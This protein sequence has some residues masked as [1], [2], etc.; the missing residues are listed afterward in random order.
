MKT[1]YSESQI[2][3]KGEIYSPDS[4]EILPKDFAQSEYFYDEHDPKVDFISKDRA[5]YEW[6]SLKCKKGFTIS[7]T[8]KTR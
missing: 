3:T 6:G 1:I 5:T 2:F 8:I 7:I 4:L